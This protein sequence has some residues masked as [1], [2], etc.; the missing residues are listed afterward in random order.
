MKKQ[1][2]I[3]AKMKCLKYNTGKTLEKQASCLGL[4]SQ[5]GPKKILIAAAHK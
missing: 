4:S 3:K 5:V 2:L 1:K